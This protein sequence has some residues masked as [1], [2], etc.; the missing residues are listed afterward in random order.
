MSVYLG[1]EAGRRDLVTWDDLEQAVDGGLLNENHW[2]ELKKDIPNKPGSNDE[3]ARDLASLAVD[4]GTLIV[5]VQ[6]KDS[7][8]ETVIGVELKGVQ[9]RIEQ[10][11]EAHIRPRLYFRAR[12][13]PHS[14]DAERAC[15]IVEV[16]ASGQAP[17]QVDVD[18]VYW[19]RGETR[20]ER[21]ADDRVREIMTSRSASLRRTAGELDA[22]AARFPLDPAQRKHGHLFVIADPIDADPDALTEM[23]DRADYQTLGAAADQA[24]ATL[25]QQ[26]RSSG[27][28]L[29]SGTQGWRTRTAG[30]ALTSVT[31][32][33]IREERVLEY[34]VRRDG[35]IEVTCGSG[36]DQRRSGWLL[37]ANPSETPASFKVVS[38]TRVLAVVHSALAFAAALTQHSHYQGRWQLGVLFDGML[39]AIAHEAL[40]T[41]YVDEENA[42]KY[43]EDRYERP[44]AATTAELV[45]DTPALVERLVGNFLRGLAMQNV[46]V[47]YSEFNANGRITPKP[48]AQ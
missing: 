34:L 10:V 13:I 22:L 27:P 1:V 21:L 42:D 41:G 15:V 6:E 48:A 46:F 40:R 25:H 3:L 45:D 26:V 33:D 14:T 43:G 9:E 36:T 31:G 23:L 2:V 11:A 19:G 30:L 29:R 47:P 37:V 16:P 18:L 38:C 28:L 7:H 35:G 39:G 24:A 17:H 32:G 44:T 4:G 12:P 20:K 8:A 5:G